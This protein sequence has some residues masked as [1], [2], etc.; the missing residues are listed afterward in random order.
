MIKDVARAGKRN[1]ISVSC[2]GESAGDPEYALLLI[3]L[4]LRTLS[5]TASSLPVLKRMVRKVSIQTCERIARKAASLDSDAAVTAFVRDQARKVIPEA[6]D[7]RSA[8][9]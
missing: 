5:A 9:R 2:C 1:N 8:D 6:F 3:G 4:G 7:G